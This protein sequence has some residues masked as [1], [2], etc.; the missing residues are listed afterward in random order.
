[1][2]FAIVLPTYNERD[3]IPL[4]IARLTEAL[5]GL[6]WEAI[7]V[8]DDSPDG[9][10]DVVSS[11]ARWDSRIRLI[12]RIGRRGLASACIEGMMATQAAFVA[13]MD[14][15]LQHDETILPRML[16]RMHRESL[17]I[18]VGTRNAEGGSMGEF[19]HG[20]VLLSE[21]G[22]RISHAVCRCELTDPMSGFFMLRRSFLLEVVRDLQGGGFKILVDLLASRRRPVAIGEI[23]YTFA[24]R[25]HGES[26]LDV[27]VGIEYLFLIVNK[28]LG[29]IIPVQLTLF[30]LV[31]GLGLV[32]H[33]A[34]LLVLTRVGHLHFVPAHVVATFIAMT[35]NFFLNN[36]ITFRSR[37]LR[38][39]RMI[40]GAARFLL[41]C[42]FG[43]WANVVFTRA[44]WQSGAQWYLAGFAGIVLGSVW[45]L[46]ISSLFT[47]GTQSRTVPQ[48]QTDEIFATDIEVSR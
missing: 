45:N 16:A 3:N 47:W 29:G 40:P 15:D 24:N 25:R 27:V 11:H 7:F 46:S 42:S 21:M 23:G 34:S 19:S 2:D 48:E 38:G 43:A 1:L 12:H 32:S 14:A 6:T 31:G 26:K 8:D 10:A 13:V 41:V 4:V 28:L 44:L 17:D 22:Q 30:L 20:R 36:L 37:R 9:T 39:L 33:L 35:E 18:A 5:R